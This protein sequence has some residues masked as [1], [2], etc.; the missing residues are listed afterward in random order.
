MHDA[1]AVIADSGAQ[2]VV[3]V[4]LGS[5]RLDGHRP[6]SPPR[7]GGAGPRAGGLGRDRGAVDAPDGIGG[8]ALRRGQGRRGGR[9]FATLAGRRPGSC[10]RGRARRHGRRLGRDVGQGG[11]RDRKLLRALR[12]SA[13][14]LAGLE[15]PPPVLHLVPAAEDAFSFE[16]QLAYETEHRWYHAAELPARSHFP[17]FEAPQQAAEEIERFVLRVGG[18]RSGASPDAGT[19]TLRPRRPA[20]SARSEAVHDVS[21]SERRRRSLRDRPLPGPLHLAEQQQIGASAAGAQH[22]AGCP[23][24]LGTTNSSVTPCTRVRRRVDLIPTSVACGPLYARGEK[25]A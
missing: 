9:P 25:V 7:A 2:S 14:A 6:A 18:R 24:A 4:A 12:E 5:C 21:V 3:P 10:A 16:R 11:A 13:E 19:S 23:P 15:H 22:H 17:L 20:E 1:F 8:R